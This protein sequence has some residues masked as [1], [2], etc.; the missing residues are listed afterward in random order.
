MRQQTLELAPIRWIF[1]GAFRLV[2]ETPRDRR[3]RF[4]LYSACRGS[5]PQGAHEK[6]DQCHNQQVYALPLLLSAQVL[7][8]QR[9]QFH[10]IFFPEL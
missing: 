2:V 5:L 10:R 4:R 6:N 8:P 1:L 9:E 7:F 3:R